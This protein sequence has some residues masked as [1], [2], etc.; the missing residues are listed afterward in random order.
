MMSSINKEILGERGT[1]TDPMT[2]TIG[3]EE[4]GSHMTERILNLTLEIILLLTGERFP[5]LKDTNQL[6]ITVPS[7]RSLILKKNN[8]K[9]ILE[10]LQKMIGLLTGEVPIRCQDVTVYFSMEEWEYLE[11]HKDLYKDVMMEDHQTLTSP[12]GSS[13][14]N[15][16]ERCPRP[17]YSRD[18]TLKGQKIPHHHQNEDLRELKQEQKEIYGRNDLPLV[19]ESRIMWPADDPNVWNTGMGYCISSPDFDTEDIETTQNSPEGNSNNG[20]ISVRS[21]SADEPSD[22]SHPEGPYDKIITTTSNNHLGCHSVGRPL[23]LYN[24]EEPST[25]V[26][27]AAVPRGGYIFTCSTVKKLSLR[28][29]GTRREIYAFECSK[30]GKCFQTQS[31]LVRNE[32]VHIGMWPYSCMECGNCFAANSDLDRHER[33]Y[34]GD[35]LP[36]YSESGKNLPTKSE[37]DTHQEHL[38][39]APS[40]KCSECG[41]CF[42]RKEYLRGHLKIHTGETPFSCAECKKSFFNKADMIRH[43]RVHTGEK[44]FSCSECGK[45]FSQKGHLNIHLKLHTGEKPFSC[46]ECGKR[47][48]HKSSLITHQTLHSGKKPF[49]CPECEKSFVRRSDLVVHQRTHTGEKPYFCSECGKSFSRKGHLNIHIKKHSVGKHL[50]VFS[51][52]SVLYREP[53]HMHL[54][55]L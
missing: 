3:M 44:P 54:P 13:N 47:F 11:G 50:P 40:Y 34:T 30:C 45:C 32:N 36:L 22:S 2:T 31:N 29:Q 5:S 8:S 48:T 14:G 20:T 27:H 15:P 1:T 4:D 28:H 33:V 24:P 10:V 23:E 12:D 46:P 42:K 53:S 43:W 17:L 26:S 41:Q 25:D 7:S 55:L 35:R 38:S 9:K 16:P 52:G 39:A 51:E 49:S 6:T 19:E 21:S 18:S 37:L